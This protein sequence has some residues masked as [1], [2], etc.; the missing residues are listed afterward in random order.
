MTQTSATGMSSF[1]RLA[2]PMVV[3][4]A[5]IAG[6]TIA[7]GVMVARHS[8]G[9]LALLGLAEGTLGRLLDVGIALLLG[10]IVLAARAGAS[11][12]AQ[13]AGAVWRRA[14]LLAMLTGCPCIFVGFTA[15]WWLAA[16]GQPPSLVSGAAPV[17]AVLSI[18]LPAALIAIATAVFLEAIGRATMVAASVI[19]ANILNIALNWLLIGGHLGLPALGAVGSAA[20]TGIVRVMLAVALVAATWMV[21]DHARLGIRSAALGLRTVQGNLQRQLGYGGAATAAALNVLGMILTLLAGWLGSLPLAAMTALFNMLSIGALLA[22]GIGDATGLQVA[23]AH[24]AHTARPLGNDAA[25]AAFRLGMI[26]MLL[27]LAI[28]AVVGLTGGA[29]LAAIYA[30]DPSLHDTL[31][32][33]I[34]LGALIMLVD[35]CAFVAGASLRG[36]GDVV[37]PNAIQIGVAATLIA[38][39][40]W[41]A[42]GHGLGAIG[43]VAAILATS[44]LRAGLLTLRF[45]SCAFS[46]ASL[47]RLAS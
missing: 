15:T 14:L 29:W 18:G 12:N 22:L 11:S 47:P 45:R 37:W 33:L 42:I 4:R 19:T 35:G 23:S 36:L 30:T 32:A 26:V 27:A 25:E 16:L 9:Q 24:G 41:L 34:P 38:L 39:A 3:S 8:T 7:D 2:I 43:I 40:W 1:L 13:E 31:T 46:A 20:S 21:P 28:P 44:M 10:G 6:M 5:G 17:I